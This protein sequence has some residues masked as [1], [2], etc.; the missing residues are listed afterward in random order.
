MPFYFGIEAVTRTFAV[1]GWLAFLAFS[2]GSRHYLYPVFEDPSLSLMVAIGVVI[3]LSAAASG[4]LLLRKRSLE[5]FALAAFL[6]LCMP[7][8]Q[9]MP[10][11]PPSL[12]SDR[13]LALA[14]WPAILFAVALLWRLKLVPR[15][16]ILLVIALLWGFQTIERPRDWRL[17]TLFDAD[18]RAY[19]GYYMPAMYEINY[20]QLPQGFI[21]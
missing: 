12:V 2:I 8:I 17:E 13:Y 19:P 20:V 6:L 1:L 15:I 5:G 4:L 11:H 14:V 16:A 21:S 7:Y 10:N 3:L 9:L 18:L